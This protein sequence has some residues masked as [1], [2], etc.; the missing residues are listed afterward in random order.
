MPH[1][2]PLA[3]RLHQF[4]VSLLWITPGPVPPRVRRTVRRNIRQSRPIRG[5]AQGGRTGGLC[6]SDETSHSP[7]LLTK[8]SS[9]RYPFLQSSCKKKKRQMRDL[10]LEE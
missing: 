2:N 3:P 5:S 9:R 1:R 8:I 10:G 7:E 6:L 4:P